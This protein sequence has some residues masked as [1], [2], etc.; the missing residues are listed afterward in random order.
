M[1]S[2]RRTTPRGFTLVELMISVAIVGVLSTVALPR[3]RVMTLR[4]RVS[5]RATIMDAVGRAVSDTVANIQALPD[6]A[7]QVLWTGILNP[8]GAQT[9]SKR[10]FSQAASGW[11][12]L[13]LIVQ[14]DTYYSYF[15]QASNPAAGA[16]TMVVMALGD[17]DGDG[18]PSQKIVNYLSAGWVFYRDMGPGGEVPAA[19]LEDATTF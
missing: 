8:A 7:N 4:A 9:P 2:R 12:W 18:T 5:E 17:L 15:F 1:T 3:Y 13:P 16:A 11:T 19:G 6:P 14:G 10:R